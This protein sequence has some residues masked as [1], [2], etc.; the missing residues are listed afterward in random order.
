MLLFISED[1]VAIELVPPHASAPSPNVPPAPQT[2]FNTYQQNSFE[3][4]QFT[5]K[6]HDDTYKQYYTL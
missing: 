3:N 5:S 4:V 1:G 6:L 2:G